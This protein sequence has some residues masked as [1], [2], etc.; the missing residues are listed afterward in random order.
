MRCKS[1]D[2]RMRQADLTINKH[3]GCDDDLCRKCRGIVYAALLDL[4][5]S[6]TDDAEMAE[7]ADN[8]QE[9]GESWVPPV[10]LT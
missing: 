5:L 9:I 1:C 2:N 3:T 10:E 4:E 7:V 6:D 8:L